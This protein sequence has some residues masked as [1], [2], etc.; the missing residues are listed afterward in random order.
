MGFDR[1]DHQ[2]LLADGA[3]VVSRCNAFSELLAAIVHN[4][5]HAVIRLHGCQIFPPGD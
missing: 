5:L 2:V 3:N 4:Q 1:Q